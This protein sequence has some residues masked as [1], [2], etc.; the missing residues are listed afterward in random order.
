MA[1]IRQSLQA[2]RMCSRRDDGRE[3]AF[4]LPSVPA[5]RLRLAH[6]AK[7]LSNPSG[8]RPRFNRARVFD[9]PPSSKVRCVSV[10]LGKVRCV[11]A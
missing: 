10:M 8:R 7:R 9:R 4:M 2:A 5:L 3:R 11:L 1:T 6:R